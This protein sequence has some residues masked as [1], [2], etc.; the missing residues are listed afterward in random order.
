[1]ALSGL[2]LTVLAGGTLPVPLPEPVLSRLRG[3]TVTE[4]DSERSA[5]TLTLDAARS[6]PLAAFDNPL[7]ADSPLQ[8]GAR[9]VLVVTL[10]AVPTV[11]FD[12]IVTQT[13]L[14]PGGAPGAA[15][16]D[17]QGEDVSCLMD[18]EERSAEYPAQS[19]F[20]QVQA[21]LAPYQAQGIAP[22]VIPAP[23]TEP[24]LPTEQVPTQQTTDLRHV[25]ALAQRNGYVAYVIPGPA[26]GTSTFYWGPPVRIGLPQPALSVDLGAQSN[27]T[28]ALTFRADALAPVAMAGDVQDPG[29][30]QSVPVL[31]A[32]SL[33]PPLAAVPLSAATR[34]RTRLLRE[35]GPGTA[36]AM[37]RAQA[38]VDAGADAVVGEGELDG[39]RY[40]SVLRPRGLVGLRGAGWSYDGLWYVRQV[41]HQLGPGSYTQKFTIAR[42][43]YGSTVPVVIV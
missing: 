9:V 25:V 20:V 28:S 18:L 3:I 32:V 4:T 15:T 8:V 6:G 37:S 27:V 5:F 12:G 42:E 26:P 7:L 38:A 10:G 33:R 36:T 13:E 11:L 41:V 24:P 19:D 16:L 2:L 1:M 22:L 40:G 14:K 34:V 39:A 31:A 30:G 17:V 43:G 23:V 21:I 35:S 29:T